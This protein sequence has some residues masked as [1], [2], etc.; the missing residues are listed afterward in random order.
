MKLSSKIFILLAILLIAGNLFAAD[1]DSFDRFFNQGN[2]YY[3][4]KIFDSAIVA[5]EQALKTGYESSSIYFNLGNAYF[6]DGDLGHAILNYKKANRLSPGDDDIINNLKFASRYTT[7]PMEG[8]TLNPITGIMDDIVSRF[9]LNSLAWIS[10]LFF[11]LAIV[12]MILKFG[13]SYQNNIL[14][15]GLIIS[16]ILCLTVSIF[17]TY[18]YQ[19]QYLTEYGVIVADSSTVYTGPTT[20]A[21]VELEGAPGLVVEILGKAGDFYNIQF[22]NNRRGWINQKLIEII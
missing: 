8:V 18:K 2:Q 21:D 13:L 19:T 20:D 7:V 4:D 15:A 12:I 9:S 1:E 10:S 3:Q 6:K 22:E 14:K 11:V 17:T 16:V 5:Y